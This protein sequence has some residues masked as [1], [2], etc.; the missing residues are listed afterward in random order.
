MGVGCAVNA[1]F[2]DLGML[3]WLGAGA[4][5]VY[6]AVSAFTFVARHE[7]SL[8]L[9]G[10]AHAC[11]GAFAVV[12][13]LFWCWLVLAVLVPFRRNCMPHG[14]GGNSPDLPPWYAKIG[15]A[16]I[17]A[18]PLFCIAGVCFGSALYACKAKDMQGKVS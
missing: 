14:C 6:I 17:L 15:Y 11:G 1:V 3:W 4:A 5:L 10:V 16:A 9:L 13:A 12:A 8:A 7:K 18:V 2:Y